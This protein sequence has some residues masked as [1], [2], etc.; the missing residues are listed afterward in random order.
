MPGEEK[1]FSLERARAMLP[2][3]RA[4]VASLIALRADL[5]DAQ[6][7][8]RRGEPPA[9]GGLAE[10]KALEARLQEALDWFPERGI[11]LKGIAPVIV[12][13]PAS[14]DGEPALLCWLEGEERLDWYHPPATGFLGR[15]RLS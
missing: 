15:R 11:E 13:F 10:V 9:V 8:L 5:A 12:D 7:A 1:A 14:I 3:L 4:H 6:V 2:A